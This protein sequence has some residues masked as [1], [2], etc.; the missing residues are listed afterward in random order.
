MFSLAVL[1]S[2]RTR[3]RKTTETILSNLKIITRIHFRFAFSEHRTMKL[4]LHFHVNFETQK[5]CVIHK[6]IRHATVSQKVEVE[7]ALKDVKVESPVLLMRATIE[8][9]QFSYQ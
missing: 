5:Q 2:T 3:G 8:I 7:K 6:T 4:L 1:I 9:F